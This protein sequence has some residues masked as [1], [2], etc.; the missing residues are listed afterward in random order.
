[1]T[2][3]STLNRAE[4]DGNGVTATF[5]FPVYFLATG[6]LKVYI[7]DA[8]GVE[9]LM[10]A[11]ADYTVAGA[12]DP[13]GGSVTFTTPPASGERVVI[14]RDPPLT[15]EID[16]QANDAF[17]AETHERALDKLTMQVQRLSERIDRSVSL[18][19]TATDG[20]GAY[21]F[22]GN[23]I[24]AIGAPTG[25][26]DAATKAYVDAVAGL[27]SAL[28]GDESFLAIGAGGVG[29]SADAITLTSPYFPATPTAL[30]K[31]RFVPTA[32][33]TGPVTVE[34]GDGANPSWGARPL[35]DT[36]GGALGAGALK[37]GLPVEIAYAEAVNGCVLLGHRSLD[38]YARLADAQA[39]TGVQRMGVETVAYAASVQPDLAG[40]PFKDFAPL[41]GPLS[42]GMPVNCALY[43]HFLM[44]IPQDATG[45]RVIT[46]DA[47]YV[48]APAWA[49]APDNEDIVSCLVLAVSGTTATRV[50]MMS[51]YQG[52]I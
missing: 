19:E 38:G 50:L 3:S 42:L 43:D 15:Q 32:D 44:R 6:D 8:F 12:G 26:A 11:G 47:G 37:A 35:V 33:N 29:G 51:L 4:Y 36:A 23:R 49:T 28:S 18:E 52:E 25:D 39:W 34:I 13:A 31:A 1:M 46:A 5:P 7:R 14:L 40:A 24:A 22:G 2:V 10:A 48:G 9:A 21:D 20:E 27:V 16:Y 17:P 30:V 45:G 41:T